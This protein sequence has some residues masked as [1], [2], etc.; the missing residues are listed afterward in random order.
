MLPEADILQFINYYAFG[1]S[2]ITGQCLHWLVSEID[3]LIEARKDELRKRKAGV[4]I[5]NEPKF[6]WVKMM[7][8]PNITYNDMLAVRGKYNAILEEVVSQKR[9]HYVLDINAHIS[10]PLNFL[11]INKI[12]ARGKDDL[13]AAIDRNVEKFDYHRKSDIKLPDTAA[14][15][16][17]SVHP[18]QQQFPNRHRNDKQHFMH[19]SS[20]TF[21]R[22][23]Q[24]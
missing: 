21:D 24:N 2:R 11:A 16:V 3:K 13:W 12:N 5:T 9:N 20:D 7:N 17:A 23:F 15:A 1:V 6:V 18:F 10:H 8:R 22:S 4:V 14:K 19:K